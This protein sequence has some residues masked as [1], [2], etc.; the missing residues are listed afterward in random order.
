MQKPCI[1]LGSSI[2]HFFVQFFQNLNPLPLSHQNF[3]KL[4]LLTI[5]F[6]YVDIIREAKSQAEDVISK[7]RYYDTFV[8]SNGVFNLSDLML[9]IKHTN[10]LS[11]F[12]NLKQ[13]LSL[14]IQFYFLTFFSLLLGCCVEFSVILIFYLLA[15]WNKNIFYLLSNKAYLTRKVV[16]NNYLFCRFDSLCQRSPA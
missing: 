4:I 5:L 9:T 12:V 8:I 16:R 10:L 15:S 1:Q 2:L 3:Q 11:H 13:E 6:G 7:K 14:K